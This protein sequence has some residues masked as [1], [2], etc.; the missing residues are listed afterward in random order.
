M[1]IGRHTALP[2]GAALHGLWGLIGCAMRATVLACLMLF[3]PAAGAQTSADQAEQARQQVEQAM[4]D[5]DAAGG[6]RDRVAALTQVIR[7]LEDGVAVLRQSLR[8]AQLREAQITASLD[9]RKEELQTL[10]TALQAMAR[11]DGS[12]ALAH[13]DG[14][15][16]LARAGVL[17]ADASPA[18]AGRAQNLQSALQEAR[19]ISLLQAQGQ[20]TLEAGLDA[21]RQARTELNTAIAD[22]TPLPRRFSTDPARLAALIASAETLA[23]FAQGLDSVSDKAPA[24]TP[25]PPVQKGALPL[26]ARG[27]VLRKMNEADAAGVRRPGVVLAADNGALVTTPAAA[28]L[29]YAGPLLDYGTVAILEPARHVLFVFAGL[30]EVFGNL[31]EVVPAGTPIGFLGQLP[32]E[33]SSQSG[34]SSGRFLPQTLYIEVRERE[35]P[36]DPLTWFTAN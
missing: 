31:G 11:L 32:D 23:S 10:L 2:I 26:P 5:L 19:I 3:V 25:L 13:P 30:T 27:R 18:M 34:E 33:T 1:L 6:A 15:V 8:D 28:T 17:L 4:L 9:A 24:A 21:A 7:A 16:A 20:K 35:I 36:V 29:R 14:P 12:K 22:R